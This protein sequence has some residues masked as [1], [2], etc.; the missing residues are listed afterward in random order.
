MTLFLNYKAM[1]WFLL[2][3]LLALLPFCLLEKELGSR[4]KLSFSHWGS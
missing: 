4:E 1:A 2:L 3:P